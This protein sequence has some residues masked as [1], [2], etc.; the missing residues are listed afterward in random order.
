MLG[1][2]NKKLPTLIKYPGGKD[3]ELKII[4][5]E[6]PDYAENYYEP[7][8]GGGA[9]YFAINA[10]KYY[11]NDKSDEL[12]DLYYYVTI[13]D[14]TFFSKIE[15]INK[16]W[17]KLDDIIEGHKDKLI[18][19]YTEYAHENLIEETRLN[20]H[21][22]NFVIT[23]HKEFNGLLKPEF[24]IGIQQFINQL[25][26]SLTN[27]YKRMK[28]LEIERGFLKEDDLYSN[29]RSAMKSAFYTHFRYLYN[30]IK[31]LKIEKP[32]AVAIYY[33][34]REY[35][36]SSMY[37]YN[38]K[39]EFNVPF[40][41]ISYAKKML[42]NKIS[43]MK[44]PDL[45]KQLNNTVMDRLDFESFFEKYPPQKDDFVF[46]DPPYDSN[47]STYAKNTFGPDEQKRLAN[48]LI[49]KCEAQFMIV[50]KNT[51]FIKNIYLEG[52]KTKNGGIL[53]VEPFKKN[54][55]VSFQNRNDKKVEHLV[56]KNYKKGDNNDKN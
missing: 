36:Y 52:T 54:Y 40:G 5:P 22:Y 16:Y 2:K 1:K 34:I 8:I 49:K 18:S 51:E 46:L 33:F 37:R 17:K 38:S 14:E 19:T 7:F 31:T 24:N 25:S 43:R 35:C 39:G 10:P 13:Q 23:N 12:M 26:N 41:G 45:L 21:I 29:I 11:I 9:V 28:K 15:A 4:L 20:D 53:T 42:T 44:S 6:L 48:Y 50:I 56:I 27:K 55:T 47:F 30:N 3:R 32:F